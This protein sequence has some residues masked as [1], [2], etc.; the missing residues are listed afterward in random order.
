MVLFT[1]YR[2]CYETAGYLR[3]AGL[4]VP[5]LVQGWGDSRHVLADKLRNSHSGVLLGV[6]SFWEGVDFPGEELEILI[7]PKIPFPVPAEPMVEARSEK[8][9][10]NGENPFQQL[11]MPE[12]VLR[13]RQGVGRLIRSREDRGVVVFMDH[14]L[15]S[16]PY[17]ARIVS[18]LPSPVENCGGMDELIKR[19]VNWFS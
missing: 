8:M 16:R 12:A 9:R 4:K 14:R 18:S 13:L 19:M 6:A 11:F 2:M 1:S 5:V 15:Q 7:I 3:D 17:G 10:A